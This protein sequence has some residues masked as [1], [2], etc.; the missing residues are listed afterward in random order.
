MRLPKLTSHS[1]NPQTQ[2]LTKPSSPG[3]ERP[4]V[5]SI[6]AAPWDCQWEGGHQR[7]GLLPILLPGFHKFLTCAATECLHG[8][9]HSCPLKKKAPSPKGEL[10]S[11]SQGGRHKE[12]RQIGKAQTQLPNLCLTF[13]SEI[14]GAD[15]PP[16]PALTESPSEVCAL[17]K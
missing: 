11:L 8:T 14:R 10:R 4:Q 12:K 6:M 5:W 3:P 1:S 2:L 7:H 16:H 9:L 15:L 17:Q 13:L